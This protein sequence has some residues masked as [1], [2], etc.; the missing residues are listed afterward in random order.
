MPPPT[1][2]PHSR[3]A[4]RLV[5]GAVV[6]A[7]GADGV[8]ALRW[9]EPRDLDQSE[10]RVATVAD[11][12]G[13]RPGSGGSSSS[14]SDDGDEVVTSD[15]ADAAAQLAEGIDPLDVASMPDGV[16]TTGDTTPTTVAAGAPTAS[17]Q[18][19][20]LQAPTPGSYPIRVV[21]G[22]KA[23][24]GVLVVDGEQWQRRSIGSEAGPAQQLTWTE[25]GA[26]L[27]ASGE[28]GE[29]G[30][31]RWEGPAVAVPSDLRDGR[32]W[33]SR[34]ICS[35]EIGGAPVRVVR[36]E[37][38]RVSKRARTQLGGRSLD[39]WV[40]EREIALTI[41][42]ETF[43]STTVSISTE[44]FSPELGLAVY[45]T[46]RTDIPLPDGTVRSA[47]ASEEIVG[48]P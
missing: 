20:P 33:S 15:V 6:V 37:A 25:R 18:P 26:I 36:R 30:S 3:L 29:D 43:S 8:L 19:G 1:D 11:V 27:A 22:G 24:D 38:A 31:C 4:H 41:E 23:V 16:T 10:A 47:F 2:P 40:I 42:A 32:K 48:L 14:S 45:Q 5:V 44:L 34:T 12:V 13:L 7:L 35:S 9:D 39:T 17:I 46:S 28:P 21:S